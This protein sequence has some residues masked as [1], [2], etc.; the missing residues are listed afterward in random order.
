MLNNERKA[1][2]ALIFVIEG[3]NTKTPKQT[4]LVKTQLCILALGDIV[5]T[6]GEIL[7]ALAKIVLAALRILAPPS[8]RRALQQKA[9]SSLCSVL[10]FFFIGPQQKRVFE[11]S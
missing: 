5:L 3:K 10:S 8:R 9:R 2:F 11:G 7:L 1:V 4:G 6:L